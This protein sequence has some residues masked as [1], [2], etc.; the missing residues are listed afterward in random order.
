MGRVETAGAVGGLDVDRHEVLAGVGPDVG[1]PVSEPDDGGPV[2]ERAGQPLAAVAAELGWLDVD[3][4]I[5]V[6]PEAGVGAFRAVR[7]SANA[8]VGS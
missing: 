6:I 1:D 5:E 7:W 3:G 8:G 4:R 2:G